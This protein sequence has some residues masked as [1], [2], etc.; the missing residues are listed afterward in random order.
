MKVAL[1]AGAR[2]IAGTAAV[3]L[4]IEEPLSVAELTT[5]V[6]SKHPELEAIVKSSRIAVNRRFADSHD[7]VRPTD[8]VAIIPP[9]SG[10]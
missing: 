9:V 3:E 6:V 2:Q 8:E 5:A 1:F 10:G 4:T 7:E